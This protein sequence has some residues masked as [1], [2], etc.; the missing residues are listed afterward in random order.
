MKNL[1]EI[2]KQVTPSI[3]E[4][5]NVNSTAQEILQIVNEHGVRIGANLVIGGSVAKGTWLPGIHDIDCFLRFDY[6]KYKSKNEQLSDIAEK[7]LNKCFKNIKR[8]HG[9]R[10]YFQIF[11]N[12]FEIEIIP[13]INISNPKMMLNITDVSPLHFKWLAKKTKTHNLETDTRLAKKFCR[14]IGV[15]GAESFIRGLSGHVIEILTV[16]YGGFQ[17]FIKAISKWDNR[18]IVD[19]EG[20]YIDEKQLMLLMNDSKLVSKLIVVDPI[21]PERNAAAVLSKENFALLKREA[22][23]FISKP[24]S[25][26]FKEKKITLEQLKSKKTKNRQLIFCIAPNKDTTIDIAGCQ[27]VKQIEYIERLLLSF[28]FKIVRNNWFWDKNN[29]ALIWFYVDPKILSTEFRHWGPPTNLPEH[30]TAFRKQWKK[31]DVKTSKGKIY[32]DLPRKVRTVDD[33]LKEVKK[34]P[35]LDIKIC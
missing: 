30:I 27:I 17:K 31:Y 26:F 33:F 28:D 32:I 4:Q 15:Y 12:G 23:R 20:R 35:N 9:S 16:H 19:P 24:S 25:N 10:D 7:L 8:L 2:R 6:I 21:Q 13:V 22:R 11:Y 34:D 3:K 5:R 29:D 14:G 1:N 18:V